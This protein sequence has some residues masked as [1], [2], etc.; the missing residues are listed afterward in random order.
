MHNE[1]VISSDGKTITCR[2][3]H[4]DAATG[5]EAKVRTVTT[6]PDKDAFTLEMFYTMGEQTKVITLTHKRKK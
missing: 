4:I 5:K 6:L 1:G 2:G 3:T